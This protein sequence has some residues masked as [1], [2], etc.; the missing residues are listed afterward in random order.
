MSN[1]T[2]E[3][4]LDAAASC[5]SQLGLDHTTMEAV[6]DKAG[7]TRMTLYRYVPSRDELIVLVLLRDWNRSEAALRGLLG[8][9]DDLRTQL[10]E[11]ASYFVNEIA[12]RP[13]IRA[14]LRSSGGPGRWNGLEGKQVLVDTFGA[15]LRPYFV[16]H[17][18]ELRSTIDDSIEWLMRQI[19]LLLTVEPARGFSPKEARRQLRTFVVPSLFVP[20]R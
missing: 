20:D 18:G 1:D 4:I 17:R 5:F 9:H 2:H 13:Y 15:F 8:E 3:R 7:I 11:G 6:A 19:F 16:G 12:D 10:L 14:M